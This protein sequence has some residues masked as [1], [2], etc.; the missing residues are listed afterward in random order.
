MRK[1]F[2]TK[3]VHG[4][5][6]QWHKS[7]G[8]GELLDFSA[9]INPF[10]PDIDWK[11]DPATLA[12]YPDDRYEVLKSVIGRTFARSPDEI[13]VGNGS[14]EL[15][16]AFCSVVLGEGDGVFLEKPTFGEYRTRFP[17]GG[18]DAYARREG[19]IGA[20]LLQPE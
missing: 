1:E 2:P 10:P 9:N 13:A 16:R 6:V 18:S 8:G 4:G 11:P 12:D 5:T 3:V 20:L 17:H 7:H 19:G 14:V 15:I